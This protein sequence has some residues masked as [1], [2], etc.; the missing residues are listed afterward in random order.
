M[1]HE[2]SWPVGVELSTRQR[3]IFDLIVV[4]LSNKEIARTLGLGQGTVKI[5]IK[6]LFHKLGV[7]GWC[8]AGDW[9]R[10]CSKAGGIDHQLKVKAA[11]STMTIAIPK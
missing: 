6:K 8:E 4:G 2:P 1:T 3:E 9:A 10:S 7:R 5:H 11:A